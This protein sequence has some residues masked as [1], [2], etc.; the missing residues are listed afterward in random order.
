MSNSDNEYLTCSSS[1]SSNSSL[2]SFSSIP[3][4]S[5]SIESI[6][7]DV[8]K[9]FNVFHLNAQSI[10]AHFPEMLAS[11]VHSNIHAILVSETW[12]KPVLPSSSVAIPGFRLIRNDRIGKG[13]GGVAIY[14]RTHIPFTVISMSAQPPPSDAGEHLLIEVVLHH[15]KI[16]LGVYYP[17]SRDVNYF[18]SFE[19]LLESHSTSYNHTIIMGDFNT[20][21]LKQD[22]RSCKFELIVKALNFTILPLRATHNPPNCIPSLLDLILVSSPN[23]VVKHDQCAADNISHHDLIFL[24]Y[25]IRPKENLK[26]SP[27]SFCNVVLVV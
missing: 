10:T 12:L 5:D 15:T 16:L 18:S 25:K 14:L 1:I 20:C 11:F 2:D 3:S 8:P 19:T 13:G 21:L 27:K 24:S 6:I 17:N 9:N 4:L 22:R 26:K 7:S 23:H